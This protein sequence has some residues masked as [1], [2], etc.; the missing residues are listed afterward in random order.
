M[1]LKFTFSI[2]LVASLNG[3]VSA[4]SQIIIP[5]NQTLSFQTVNATSNLV[6]SQNTTYNTFIGSKAGQA[7]TTG[8]QNAFL[9]AY[10]G[11]SNTSGSNNTFLGYQTGYKNTSGYV[12][13]F[14]GNAAGLSNTSGW[15]NIFIGNSAGYSNT[16]GIANMFLGQQAGFNS[17]GDYNVF[18]GNASGSATV[19]GSGNTA[20][21]DGSLLRNL[22]GQHNTAIGQYAGVES[23]NDENVFIGYGADVTPAT[24]NITNAVAIGARAR[25]SKSNSVILGGT[26]VSSVSVGIGNTAPT[27]SLHIT[28]GVTNSSG[29][30]LEN[31]TSSS[32]AT[33]FSQYKFLSVDGS[34]NVI[35]ASLNGS[36]RAGAELWEVKGD[37]LQNANEGSVIIGQGISKTPAGYK[38][39]VEEGILTEKVK[40]AV[41]STT[42]WSDK[43]FEAGYPLKSLREVAQYI[44]QTGH[45][46][47][48]PS[49]TEVVEK[50]IDVAKMDAKLLE[51][52]E[53]LTLYSIQ[54]EKDNQAQKLINQ[55]Q[56][57]ELQN[58]KQSLQQ[59]QQKQAQLEQ[60]VNTLINTKR[61]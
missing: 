20:I 11:Q 37:N 3:R 4:Q 27:A 57:Q 49:A 29:L 19:S 54:L 55:Q 56:A 46:P 5:D 21:G 33:A 61:K 8:S 35:L 28:T 34:G 41:K 14:L 45:L 38:L 22:T 18:L 53:E 2:L 30:R 52:V 16:T 9:G 10:A 24:P 50:G 1:K 17:T 23:K 60:L 43:V 26:G 15:G 6:V 58:V 51:K 44:K 40:V 36:A 13:M 59:Q 7:N 47:G 25:V 31:L 42:D 32:P 48:V 12:N 39:F